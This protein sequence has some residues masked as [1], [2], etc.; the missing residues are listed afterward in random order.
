MAGFEMHIND[1]ESIVYRNFRTTTNNIGNLTANLINQK[2][3]LVSYCG[4]SINYITDDLSTVI[5][6]I[7]KCRKELVEEENTLKNIVDSVVRN[8]TSAYGIISG[9]NVTTNVSDT[10][11][12]STVDNG[13]KIHISQDDFGK[14]I[15]Q[16][17]YYSQRNSATQTYYEWLLKFHTISGGIDISKEDYIALR[18]LF[19]LLIHKDDGAAYVYSKTIS[20]NAEDEIKDKGYS[21]GYEAEYNAIKHVAAY[22]CDG[23][24]V[25]YTLKLGTVSAETFAGMELPTFTENDMEK[26]QDA[27]SKASSTEEAKLVLA[28]FGI[29]LKGEIEGITL[30]VVT[31]KEITDDVSVYSKVSITIGEAYAKA[32]FLHSEVNSDGSMEHSIMDI[33]IGAS[34]AEITSTVGI[35]TNDGTY[36]LKGGLSAGVQWAMKLG[37]ES[38]I[39]AALFSLGIEIDGGFDH[40]EWLYF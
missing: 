9:E 3:S 7:E 5:R 2:N 16:F 11:A 28:E 4:N 40:Y 37:S 13:D 6:N 23:D 1:I 14:L 20:N 27:I 38:E 8:E 24:T 25:E 18:D 17:K 21:R 32:D 22:G 30:D 19:N 12:A 31:T 35:K 26:F 10:N 33:G 29:E 39:K 15:N 36:A 34:A